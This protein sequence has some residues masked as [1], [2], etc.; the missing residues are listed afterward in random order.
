MLGA[1]YGAIKD[2]V[3]SPCF[4]ES[5][6]LEINDNRC[7]PYANRHTVIFLASSIAYIN[8]RKGSW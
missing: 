2:S 1:P 3:G 4:I 6:S 8:A 5:K 7:K